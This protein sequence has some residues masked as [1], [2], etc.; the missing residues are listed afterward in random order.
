MEKGDRLMKG[1]L[2]NKTI[3]FHGHICPGIAV[4]Y[5][6]ALYAARLLGMEGKRLDSSHFVIAYNNVC[7]LDGIQVI[8]GCSI[9]N[10]GLFIDNRG[11]QA[12]SFISKKDGKG[13]RLALAVPL[14]LSDEPVAL[15][16]KVRQGVATE[17]EKRDFIAQRE[18]RGFEMLDYADE[19]MFFV[20]EAAAEPDTAARLHPAERC[21]TCGEN[22]MVPWMTEKEGKR[23]CPDCA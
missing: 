11:K 19:E 23:V 15:H 6:A 14:W 2:W 18:R 8:T 17:E 1:H 20:S 5:R 7:G 10:A 22:V 12:F 3:E 9:G 4:G 21:E 16:H 13:I